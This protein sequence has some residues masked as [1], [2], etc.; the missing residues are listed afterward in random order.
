MEE[1][2]YPTEIAAGKSSATFIE[3]LQSKQ[4]IGNEI[5]EDSGKYQIDVQKLLG[6]KTQYG[7]GVASEDFMQDVYML[8]EQEYETGNK[9]F[10]KYASN[11]PIKIA[12]NTLYDS[13]YQ[14][15]YYGISAEDNIVLGTVTGDEKEDIDYSS[16]LQEYFNNSAN[17]GYDEDTV[18]FINN[19]TIKDAQTSIKCMSYNDEEMKFIIKYNGKYYKAKENENSGVYSVS[20][21]HINL[22]EFGIVDIGDGDTVLVTPSTPK[23]I[24]HLKYESLKTHENAYYLKENKIDVDLSRTYTESFY[25]GDGICYNNAGEELPIVVLDGPKTFIHMNYL[26]ENGHLDDEK[27]FTEGYE[28]YL[29]YYD[30]D[31]KK[32]DVGVQAK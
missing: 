29:N 5:G 9:K 2:T 8:E 30:L 16:L 12:S 19:E 13:K 1:F 21:L 22:S 6:E 23:K 27:P 26:N 11:M 18:I 14:I 28:S 25:I 31:G 4:I 24:L 7:N 15:I 3:Y 20:R 10:T 32:V 17:W